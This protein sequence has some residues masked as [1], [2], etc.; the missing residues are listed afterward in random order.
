MNKELKLWEKI[1]R[2][3]MS[4]IQDPPAEVAKV[5]QDLGKVEFTARALGL[6]CRYRGLDMVKTLVEHGATFLF[7]PEEIKP[8]FRHSQLAYLDWLYGDENYSLGLLSEIARRETY[9]LNNIGKSHCGISLMPSEERLKT[10]DYLYRNAK[11]I[12]F[13]PDE[14]LFYAYFSLKWEMVDYLKDK[15][16][17]VSEKLVKTV[18]E[19]GNNYNWMNYSW[20]TGK[21]PDEQFVRVMSAI[22]AECGGK[23]LHFTDLFWH[24]NAKRFEKPTVFK[25]LLDNFNQSKMNKTKL[26]KK[27]IDLGSVE[28]L[29]LCAENGWLK[30]FR[31]C[32]EMI[33]YATEKGKTECAAWLLEFQNRSFDLSAERAK[34]EKKSERELNANPNTVTEL[35]KIWRFEKREDGFVIITGYKGT[36]SEIHVPKTIG[37]SIVT[38]IGNGAFSPL[39]SRISPERCDFRTRGITKITLAETI[40]I[41]DP[42]AF[43]GC[44][45]LREVVLPTGLTD[46]GYHAFYN[47]PSLEKLTLSG[48]VE[49]I[50][51]EAFAECPRLTVYVRQGSHAERYCRERFIRFEI[52]T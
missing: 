20:L 22:I 11:K 8:A 7:D 6:A 12:G 26:L 40:K 50:A 28:C 36:R 44:R 14:F 18:T 17:C 27:S 25:F 49:Y 15:G 23:K 2:L 4:V 41:I 30:T 32:E 16:V 3:E 37:K 35:K 24:N 29:A 38:A 45:S 13:A 47:C 19:G 43:S 46:I 31:K 33:R 21:L 51:E 34:A 42:F 52:Y 1:E 10:L 5:C 48:G 9:E 39:Q